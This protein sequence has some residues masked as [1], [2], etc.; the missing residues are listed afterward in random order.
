V[1]YAQLLRNAAA[2]AQATLAQLQGMTAGGTNTLINGA[3]YVGVYGP[4]VIREDMHPA[5]GHR[6]LS[7]NQVALTREQFAAA[8]ASQ[9]DLTR[10]D[11][12]P[13][14]TYRIASVDTHDPLYY[15]LTLAKV[16]V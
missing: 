15:I 13:P 11:I 1:S 8:P 5:G 7:E 12:S 4:P 3:A 6:R 9:A 2:Q 10:T 16:G 14:I